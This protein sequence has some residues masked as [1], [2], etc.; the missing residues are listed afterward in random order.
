MRYTA[1]D[2]FVFD[3]Q[4]GA[5]VSECFKPL[6]AAR[7]AQALNLLGQLEESYTSDHDAMLEIALKALAESRKTAP[8][9]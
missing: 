4:E 7:V 3:Q 6:S 5:H 9:G 8:R 2:S 1:A